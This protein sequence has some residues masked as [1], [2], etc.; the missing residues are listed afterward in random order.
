[1][2]SS[3]HK[4]Q[5]EQDV[6]T[7]VA[8]PRSESGSKAAVR[9]RKLARLGRTGWACHVFSVQLR[10]PAGETLETV[11]AL[12]RQVH[13]TADTDAIENV[14][15]IYCPPERLVRVDVPVNVFGEEVCPG[16]KA[17]GRINWMRRTIPCTAPGSKIPKSF[18]IDVSQ[19][20]LNQKVMLAQ[21]QLPEGVTLRDPNRSLPV[22]K[23][24]K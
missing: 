15:L 8:E 13:I 23:I 10:G 5:Q 2:S 18:E 21:L 24:S 7:L 17:G 4:R 16:L 1:M 20:G 11:P 22:I 9:L 6:D 3:D 19:M 14:T 12:G